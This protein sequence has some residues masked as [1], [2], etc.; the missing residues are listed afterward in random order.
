M[1]L[2]LDA[3]RLKPVHEIAD[4]SLCN[5][6]S[7]RRP[8][9][10]PGCVKASD[11]TFQFAPAFREPVSKQVEDLASKRERRIRCTLLS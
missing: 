4:Y 9:V 3:A 7:D 6:R 2:D 1:G 11:R 5:V 8:H 10:L